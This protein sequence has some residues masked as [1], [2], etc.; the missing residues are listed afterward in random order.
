[1]K[2][3]FVLIPLILAAIGLS[4]GTSSAGTLQGKLVNGSADGPGKA[5]LIELLDLTQGMEVIATL[6]NVE[7]EFLFEDA[8]DASAA[9]FLLRITSQGITYNERVAPESFES[10]ME[11]AVYDATSDRSQ[12]RV[13]IH[14]V[15]FQRADDHMRITE[16]L[17]FNNDTD[18][19]QVI[20]A[21]AQPMRIHLPHDIHGEIE[22][23]VGAGSMPLKLDLIETADSGVFT[24]DYALKPGATRLV[25]RY[26]G[27][28]EDA[29]FDWKPTVI[30]STEERRVLVSPP[31]VAVDAPDM[32]LSPDADAP[33]G[34]VVWAGLAIEGGSEWSVNLTGG[35]DRAVDL[36]ANSEAGPNDVQDVQ[37]RPNR[38]DE[39]RNWI[40]GGL[41]L[42]FLAAIGFAAS[43]A[44][45]DGDAKKSG[46]QKRDLLSRLSDRY[47]SGEIDRATFETERDRL[48]RSKKK[49]RTTA[50]AAS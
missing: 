16:L 4:P 40:F 49:Q 13:H 50:K 11:V 25:V 2:I 8:P 42:L 39:A 47:V 45:K 7:G 15:L 23:S 38:Y 12:L 22:V 31:D 20:D 32:I 48:L 37:V 35:S 10:P 43:S 1:M 28:Y 19:P 33:E 27:G 29:A 26:E 36:Q 44:P 17:Q 41:T 21:A 9:H 3:N 46:S 34:Y 24:V 6:E 18:P 5:E 14:D 30:Y